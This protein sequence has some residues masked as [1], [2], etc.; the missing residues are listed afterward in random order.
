MQS[1]GGF[2][3][4]IRLKPRVQSVLVILAL[5]L[6]FLYICKY[7]CL[8]IQLIFMSIDRVV[9]QIY[10]YLLESFHFLF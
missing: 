2:T 7:N 1:K 6:S 9:L 3:S 5:K 10:L 8:G 4:S